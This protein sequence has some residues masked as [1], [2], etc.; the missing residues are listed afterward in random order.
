QEE[1]EERERSL[2]AT[3]HGSVVERIRQKAI[4][5][6]AQSPF[7]VRAR[8]VWGLKVRFCLLVSLLSTA[9]CGFSHVNDGSGGDGADMAG[10]PGG[11][12]DGGAGSGGGGGGSGGAGGGGGTSMCTGCGCDAPV[13]LVAVQSVDGSQSNDGRV[14]QLSV[15]ASGP[16]V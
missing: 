13:L 15:P 5:F 16:A 10:L 7:V 4:W 11:N 14:L 6:D 12:G 8:V 9:C 1:S 3:T 2:V